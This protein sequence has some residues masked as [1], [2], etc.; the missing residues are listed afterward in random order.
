M[1]LGIVVVASVIVFLASLVY[2]R[3]SRFGKFFESNFDM[4]CCGR[5]AFALVT[6]EEARKGAYMAKI[7]KLDKETFVKLSS[8]DFT[9]SHRHALFPSVK[10]LRFNRAFLTG[11]SMFLGLQL[12]QLLPLCLYTVVD[13]AAL[14]SFI[15][16][17][18]S[19][20]RDTAASC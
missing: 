11:I 15:M 9:R 4:A 17:A 18:S 3:R 8:L 13:R 5:T 14:C 2:L 19:K 12:E 6:E 10:L 1:E 16:P 20:S 7:E